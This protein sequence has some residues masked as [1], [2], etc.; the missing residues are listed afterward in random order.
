MS[1][2][3]NIFD[4]TTLNP[5]FKTLQKEWVNQVNRPYFDSLNQAETK[6]IRNTTFCK[7]PRAS[8]SIY[9]RTVFIRFSYTHLPSNNTLF[10]LPYSIC[11]LFHRWNSLVYVLVLRFTRWLIENGRRKRVVITWEQEVLGWSLIMYLWCKF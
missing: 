11:V 7:T 5:E 10:L 3:N 2:Y 1:K 8:A 6:Q 9:S 4:F